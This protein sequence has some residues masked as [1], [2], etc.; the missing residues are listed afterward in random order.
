MK[1]LGLTGRG[2]MR[3]KA[4]L[5]IKRG[6]AIGV[7]KNSLSKNLWRWNM[8][9]GMQILSEDGCVHGAARADPMPAHCIFQ[10]MQYKGSKGK[11]TAASR[12][13]ALLTFRSQSSSQSTHR[14]RLI[15][16]IIFLLT[17]LQTLRVH[18]IVNAFSLS[19]ALLTCDRR[20]MINRAQAA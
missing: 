14:Q 6:R 2:A 4:I 20:S 8:W 18:A 13:P 17:S 12:S 7:L 19:E 10:L 11:L 3:L 16:R 15:L 1:N 9:S 5:R